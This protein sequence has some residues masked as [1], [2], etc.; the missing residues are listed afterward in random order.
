MLFLPFF[1]TVSL[2]HG[3]N[4][5]H[6]FLFTHPPPLFPSY[7]SL[8]WC[9]SLDV[10]GPLIYTWEL[11]SSPWLL[12]GMIEP[13]RYRTESLGVSPQEDTKIMMHKNKS[14][15]QVFEKVAYLIYCHMNFKGTYLACGHIVL[16]RMNSQTQNV[17][18]M[19]QVKTLCVL[20]SII[21]D[22]Y[23][24]HMVHNF[25]NLSV[26]KITSTV[27]TS[28]TNAEN[29]SCTMHFNLSSDQYLIY[30]EIN[31]IQVT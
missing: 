27:I 21:D 10:K 30:R 26:E 8:S 23:C 17:I 12:S 5:K 29:K 2:L 16:Q 20:L 6:T 7:S 25:T 14:Q 11:I 24:C 31:I 28:V 13:L 18:I 1:V 15:K 19:T 22:T 3:K 9:Y 4:F